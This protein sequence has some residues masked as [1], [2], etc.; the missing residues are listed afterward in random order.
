MK[1]LAKFI[2]DEHARDM[3]IS[4]V[5]GTGKTTEL[6]QLISYC[7]ANEVEY[8]ACAFTH[9][10]CAI[11]RTKLPSGAN[12]K[13]LHSFLGKCPTINTRALKKEHVSTNTKGRARLQGLL[14]V[15]EYSMVGERDYKE[16]KQAGLKVVW[17]GDPHQLPPVGDKQAVTPSG[18][19]QTKLTKIWRNNNPLQIPLNALISYIDGEA[20][21]TALEPVQNYFIRGK[22]LCKEYVACTTSKI[23]LAYT[24][25]RVQE[26]NAQIAGRTLPEEND[27]VYSP[28]TR[29]YYRFKGWVEG[30]TI[31]DVP[32]S[33]STSTS[34]PDALVAK[35]ENKN[36]NIV[37]FSAVFGYNNFN[38]KKILNSKLAVQA[39][40]VIEAKHKKP[41][42]EW[43]RLNKTS[44]LARKRGRAWRECLNFN[45]CTVCLDFPHA[46]TVHKSQGSTYHT[47]LVDTDD[48]AKCADRNFKLYLK[49]LYVAISRASNKVITN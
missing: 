44:S 41:A 10:A 19:Y 39:N 35:L 7:I 22:D 30:A 13:T 2:A 40:K 8:T 6:K 1:M 5:A 29:E 18:P 20:P 45:E 23:L 37:Y 43:A 42:I 46:M 9:K 16:I 11:M 49:L 38:N 25:K 12:V 47:V 27:L 32:Y 24:N 36:K 14:F 4:G 15:D 48:I 31:I 26:L 28:T 34:I 17:I 33:N 21:P 3:Y